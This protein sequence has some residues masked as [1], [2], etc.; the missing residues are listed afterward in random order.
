MGPYQTDGSHTIYRQY[1]PSNGIALLPAVIAL[2]YNRT[3]TELTTY[4]PCLCN[5]LGPWTRLERSPAKLPASVALVG[6]ALP[7]VGHDESVEGCE[8][9]A[10]VPWS[11][12]GKGGAILQQLA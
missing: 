2:P 12:E 6:R 9:R 7:L 11:P 5:L 1:Y 10:E 4:F 3:M 8:H